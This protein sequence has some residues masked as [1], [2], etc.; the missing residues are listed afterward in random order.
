M[1]AYGH[2]AGYTSSDVLRDHGAR[3][4]LVLLKKGGGGQTLFLELARKPR[5][6]RSQNVSEVG[7]V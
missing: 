5:K 4:L 6:D 2:V 1:D 3:G 7:L